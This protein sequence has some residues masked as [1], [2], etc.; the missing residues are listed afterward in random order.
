MKVGSAVRGVLGVVFAFAA[1]LAHA[2][3][4]GELCTTLNTARN[5][6]G[7][8]NR[9]IAKESNPLKQNSLQQ[10]IRQ[11]NQQ[12]E[13]Y[14]NNFLIANH[15]QFTNFTGVVSSFEVMHYNVGPGVMLGISLPCEINIA[16]Q[17]I[18]ITNPAWGKFDPESQS[19]LQK[20]RTALENIVKGDSVT[21]SGRFV[22]NKGMTF[23]VLTELR[24]RGGVAYSVPD[25]QVLREN[26]RRE[27]ELRKDKIIQGIASQLSGKWSGEW[28][29]GGIVNPMATNKATFNLD[30]TRNGSVI[31]GTYYE[32]GG[33]SNISGSVDG[34][35]INFGYKYSDGSSRKFVGAISA[36]GEVS[37]KW[38]QKNGSG[39]WKM[40]KKSSPAE[41]SNSSTTAQQ[42]EG[43]VVAGASSTTGAAPPSEI[44]EVVR[45]DCLRMNGNSVF[46]NH[47]GFAI[48]VTW[49]YTMGKPEWDD[50][51]YQNKFANWSYLKNTCRY[52]RQYESPSIPPGGGFA[53]P[54]IGKPESPDGRASAGLQ[55]V[56]A[57][58]LP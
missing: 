9:Q 26:A 25:E 52:G 53:F 45:R 21:F 42:S 15:R 44:S 14:L 23:A 31:T 36:T 32:R 47:C 50:E 43:G 13:A 48:G 17:F 5:N 7:A 35:Q 22:P 39:T 30:L 3:Q 46:V 18:E 41:P 19:S 8:L 28:E 4:M 11:I 2:D 10:Q 33:S 12:R 40:V 1:S 16:F 27:D 55:F 51:T 58:K 37:G 6:Q 24:K 57:V 38:D 29:L 56:R 54:T 34:R 20:W 49:C